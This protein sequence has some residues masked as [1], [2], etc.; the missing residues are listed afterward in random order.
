MADYA[1]GSNPPY[2]LSLKGYL[3]SRTNN[4]PIFDRTRGAFRS[5]LKYTRRGWPDICLI[6]NG[7]FYG[8][9]VKA[10]KGRLSPEHEQLG[11]ETGA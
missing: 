8:I 6:H 5:L 7:I 3:I 1:F 10:A 4:A 11:R 2:E 9:E